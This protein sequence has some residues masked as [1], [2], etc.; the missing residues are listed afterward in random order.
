MSETALTVYK[1][2]EAVAQ[3]STFEVMP[4]AFELAKR[5]AATEFVPVPLRNK[6]EA[7]AACILQGHEV[8][9]PPMASLAHIHVIEGRPAISAA[10]QRALILAHGHEIWISEQTATRA[11]VCGRRKS[12]ERILEVTWSLDDAKRAGLLGKP[13]WQKYPRNMLVARATG[14]VGR[15]AFM[16]VLGGIPYSVEELEDGNVID[17]E[18]TGDPTTAAPAPEPTK[19]RKAGRAATAGADSEPPPAPEPEAAGGEAAATA[20]G[21]PPP[22]PEV[23]PDPDPEAQPEAQPPAGVKAEG[24]QLSLAQQVAI[25]CREL[26]I[27]RADLLFAVTGKTSGREISREQ[28]VEV[29]NSARAIQRNEMRLVNVDGQ[30]WQLLPLE[31]GEDA[32]E[33]G[34]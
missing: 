16:D 20:E 2:N 3:M 15:G 32:D 4:S 22:A 19:R 14:D 9:L 30:G 8:G 6:P 10:G 25:I 31:Q 26:N 29:L 34:E 11:T 23:E 5:L 21:E 1:G 33:W 13:V 24:E 18:P 27:E 17:L 28:A 7:V 12:E